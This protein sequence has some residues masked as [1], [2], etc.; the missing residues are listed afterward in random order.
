VRQLAGMNMTKQGKGEGNTPETARPRMSVLRDT[1]GQ[2][3]GQE[4]W[5]KDDLSCTDCLAC[6]HVC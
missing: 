6:L 5:N 3:R 4:I 1:V 2:D